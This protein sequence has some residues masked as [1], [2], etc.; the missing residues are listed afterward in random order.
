[1]EA[2]RPVEEQAAGS[3]PLMQPVA[4]AGDRRE[5]DPIVSDLPTKTGVL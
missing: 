5:G 2:Y 3:R 4:G 1:M